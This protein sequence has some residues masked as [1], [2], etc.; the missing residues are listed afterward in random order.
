MPRLQL[1]KVR[2]QKKQRKK[3]RKKQ[4]IYKPNKH[5]GRKA[6][7]K[8]KKKTRKYGGVKGQK[9]CH[10][11]NKEEC[12]DPCKWDRGACILKRYV[13]EF[14]KRIANVKQSDRVKEMRAIDE[15]NRRKIM[16]LQH[17]KPQIESTVKSM[18]QP[19]ARQQSKS[20]FL[21]PSGPPTPLEKLLKKN[22]SVESVKQKK[23]FSEAEIKQILKYM[24]SYRKKF[25]LAYGNKF[26]DIKKSWN[27][28]SDK[29][30][31]IVKQNW[32]KDTKPDYKKL[33]KIYT[34]RSGL[35]SDDQHKILELCQDVIIMFWYKKTK[36]EI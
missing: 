20:M 18:I 35:S 15:R 4:T 3:Q 29:E 10:E 17:K 12:I 23:T 2:Y 27:K 21:A 8:T 33:R 24:N 9:D 14:E 11:L 5:K 34:Y 7:K 19:L 25:D 28:L 36:P 1:T 31:D 22:V 26:F 16:S 32:S 6:R 30:K 13:S